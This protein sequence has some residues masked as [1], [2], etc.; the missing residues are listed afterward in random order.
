VLSGELQGMRSR[1]VDE[2]INSLEK[3]R[4]NLLLAEEELWRQRSRA[5]WIKSGDQNTNFFHHFASFRRNKKHIWEVQDESG[6]VHS[7]N[8]VILDEAL[9][10][11]KGSFA[12]SET[13]IADRVSLASPFPRL[14]TEQ[15]SLL[16]ESPCT[17]EELWDVLKAFAKDR[18]PGPDGWTMEFFIHFFELVGDELLD[19][20][21]DS[22][23]RGVVT[24]ALNST[25][26]VLI[27]KVNK[28]TTF[29]DFRPISLC[30]LCYKIIAKILAN[31][32]KPI[33]SRTL[34]KRNWG[35]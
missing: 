32:I 4:S 23:S 19:V 15:D 3:E 1:E 24:K 34:S 7:G 27:P 8:E 13:H 33:L 17:R 26:L 5:T 20:V 6:Q 2:H 10:Y 30:N 29:G 11:F 12:D 28:P 25:F 16:L 21:E 18:S 22:R 31:M 9:R 35:F 14:V